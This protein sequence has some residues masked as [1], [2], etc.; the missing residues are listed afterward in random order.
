MHGETIPQGTRMR[1]RDQCIIYQSVRKGSLG[2]YSEDDSRWSQF[3]K[4]DVDE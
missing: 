3:Q 4:T 1:P 2:F